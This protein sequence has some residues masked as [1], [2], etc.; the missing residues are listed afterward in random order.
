MLRII[1]LSRCLLG[2]RHCADAGSKEGN[3]A[4]DRDALFRFYFKYYLEPSNLVVL[5]TF[6]V[7]ISSFLVASG[8]HS[9]QHMCR[10]LS[11]LRKV[12]LDKG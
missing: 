7:L 1:N 8:Y 12:L 6:Q 9:R 10:V 2:A 4:Q 3:E 5:A 11:S